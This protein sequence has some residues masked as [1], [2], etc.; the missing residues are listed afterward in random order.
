MASSVPSG[1]DP[2]AQIILS[3]ALLSQFRYVP[4]APQGTQ[5]LSK[6]ER[7]DPSLKPWNVLSFLIATAG[8]THDEMANRVIAVSGSITC[9]QI[10]VFLVSRTDAVP[11]Q[12]SP[13]TRLF[14]P[15][16]VTFP[17]PSFR[18]VQKVV[19]PAQHI[20][21][22]VNIA[23]FFAT[24]PK[25]HRP[26]D[27]DFFLF[28]FCVSR[29]LPK[30]T[31]RIENGDRIWSGPDSR[32]KEPDGDNSRHPTTAVYNALRT[33]PPENI[34]PN[35]FIHLRKG[36]RIRLKKAKIPFSPHSN[37][38]DAYPITNENAVDWAQLVMNTFQTMRTYF[39]DLRSK[40]RVL[41]DENAAFPLQINE[42]SHAFETMKLFRAL[43]DAGVIKHILTTEVVAKLQEM[44]RR[45]EES[46]SCPVEK[47]VKKFKV[48]KFKA[49]GVP[50]T[51]GSSTAVMA[52][53]GVSEQS[54]HE[55]VPATVSN[56]QS[57]APSP[58]DSELPQTIQ[59]DVS[60]TVHEVPPTIHEDVPDEETLE[61]ADGDDDDDD[62]E[63]A[64][65]A[66]ADPNESVEH[67]LV[68]YLRTVT[69]P[70]DIII[71]F[72]GLSSSQGA[73]SAPAVQALYV[74]HP[75]AQP[76]ARQNNF[77]DIEEKMS[78][79]L[80]KQTA[81]S[82]PEPGDGPFA[83]V[84]FPGIAKWPKTL[85][86]Q[87][88]QKV[89]GAC[90]HAEAALM[91]RAWLSRHGGDSAASSEGEALIQSVFSHERI[92]VGVSKKC[93]VC[94]EY[95]AQLLGEPSEDGQPGVE[96]VFSGTHSTVFPWVPPSGLPH[97]VL[98]KLAKKLIAALDE[99]IKVSSKDVGST[100]TTPLHASEELPYVGEDE[101]EFDMVMK[102]REEWWEPEAEEY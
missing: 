2:A 76:I 64:A 62:E 96:F 49:K 29:C 43:L 95:L 65:D 56:V 86:N 68:R 9:G 80:T 31:S 61:V 46:K 23:Q 69:L 37:T 82:L 89:N 79:F 84:I 15:G 101:D 66:R 73:G 33:T 24:T 48:R 100:Q 70:L 102:R 75:P 5:S 28:L 78:T 92:P 10:T 7:E 53:T 41:K 85:G 14:I 22:V 58:V 21:D 74:N 47:L 98:E 25:D 16:D 30:L 39:C 55:D 59:E 50:S 88:M 94:C 52:S 32:T 35:T 91:A 1:A 99:A 26:I 83:D 67:H 87:V 44:R 77:T 38:H 54:T 18:R 72:I 63:E 27:S 97:A 90:V 11:G 57:V 20:G 6:H 13:S 42:S 51:R 19:D 60:P 81:G 36:L 93:C 12:L 71:T 40:W 4:K 34:R 8:D 3:S 45:S 17:Q